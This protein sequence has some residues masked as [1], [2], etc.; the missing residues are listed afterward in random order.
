MWF[1][2]I[3]EFACQ[4]SMVTPDNIKNLISEKRILEFLFFFTKHLLPDILNFEKVW[5]WDSHG[6]TSYV[7]F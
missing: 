6:F 5:F 1:G 3:D 4:K 7:Q 2:K